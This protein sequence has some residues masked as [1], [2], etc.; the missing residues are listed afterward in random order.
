VQDWTRQIGS[1]KLDTKKETELLPGFIEDVFEDSL[2]YTRPPA[3]P[4]T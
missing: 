4:Y 1:K 2:G 3:D